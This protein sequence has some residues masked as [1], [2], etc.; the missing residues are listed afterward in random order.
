[1]WK[2][3]LECL[4]L[5]V[6]GVDAFLL[7]IPEGHQT[8]EDK[9]ALKTIEHFF[10]EEVRAF[11][12]TVL[13]RPSEQLSETRHGDSVVHQ[14][15]GT[16][17]GPDF[18][19]DH[20]SKVK[21][22][23]ERVMKMR[24]DNRGWYSCELHSDSQLKNHL[25]CHSQ[26]KERVFK[27]ECEI[28]ELKSS[29][30]DLQEDTK[31]LRIVLLGKTGEGKSASGNTI[32]GKEVFNEDSAFE[33]VTTVC[34]KETVIINGRPITVI[35][36]PGL[37]DTETDNTEIKKEIVKCI[38]MAA[39][40]PH[41]FLL[42]KQ[43][44]RFTEEERKAVKE[45]QVMFGDQSRMYTI[46]LFTHG[47]KLKGKSIE[48]AGSGVNSLLRAFGMRYHVIDNSTKDNKVQVNGLLSKIDNLVEVNGGTCY[49][50]EMFE[51]VEEALKQE[52]ER[53]LLEKKETIERE[54]QEQLSK[55][56][57]EMEK[58]K[59]DMEEEKRKQDEET[60]RR[61][62][63][64]RSKEKSMRERMKEAMEK[65]EQEDRRK[66][67]EMEEKYQRKRE[68]NEKW[69]KERT[70]EIELER[71]KW[72][73]KARD[74]QKRREEEEEKRKIEEDQKRQ[75]MLFN[76]REQYNRTVQIMLKSFDDESMKKKHEYEERAEKER[77][78]QKE[79]EE[80]IK[81]SEESKVKE[82]EEQK[83]K[84]EE[85]CQR[86]LEK[87]E[88]RLKEEESKWNDRLE[89]MNK[90]WEN[91]QEEERKRHEKEKLEEQQKRDAEEKQ[92]KIQ[93]EQE[94]KKM[95][96]D[97]ER[98]IKDTEDRM[99]KL[100]LEYDQ[101]LREEKH[102]SREREAKQ[103]A[104]KEEE[105]RL[106]RKLFD[107]E[108]QTEVKASEEREKRNIEYLT[109]AHEKEKDHLKRE[110]EMEARRQAE[111]EFNKK[112]DRIVEEAKLEG[113]E[114]GIKTVQSERSQAGRSLDEIIIKYLNVDF[115]HIFTQ[116]NRCGQRKK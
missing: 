27:L 7:I 91:K 64:F 108:M 114:E 57:A 21:P 42:V 105:L 104:E 90:D 70:K 12:L 101:M 9:S 23:L 81:H 20:A 22:L 115:S 35:D 112:L 61:E 18:I 52:Q 110:V 17:E 86:N 34:Q 8:D 10:G 103:R 58:L 59:K 63:E 88:K 16:S 73:T 95:W 80:K 2:E 48:R 99:T 38:G 75:E 111:D 32:L 46:V 45:I 85:E 19:M 47:K 40:G 102:R 37:F 13:M 68:E 11:C 56:V 67:K 65:M 106:Q 4:R 30:Q 100:Q 71:E 93:E 43:V 109:K 51:K 79:L 107:E 15:T 116:L 24:E 62:E 14:G 96:Q 54:K 29:K 72:E 36:T 25:S 49:T 84:H 92:R 28:N 1:M 97:T 55:H 76:E 41:V 31:N 5:C 60:K 98:K 94:R 83:R 87:E 66:A 74:D 39:P 26:F 82:L 50:N 89:S 33:S 53:I 6:S 69:I 77:E 78:K 113:Y 44:G 3:T